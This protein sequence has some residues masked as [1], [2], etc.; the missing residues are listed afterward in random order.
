MNTDE[1]RR[2][3]DV[4]AAEKSGGSKLTLPKQLWLDMAAALILSGCKWSEKF[5]TRVREL[6][7]HAANH[8]KILILPVER[9]RELTGGYVYAARLTQTY[10]YIAKRVAPVYMSGPFMQS[11]YSAHTSD[12]K[13]KVV[14]DTC[15]IRILI[16]IEMLEGC[17]DEANA[18]GFNKGGFINRPSR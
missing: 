7:P 16:F 5:A 11:M 1:I 9:Q 13:R 10:K 17:F 12:R 18:I 3:L 15:P 6:A 14:Y 8:S 4:P 2:L